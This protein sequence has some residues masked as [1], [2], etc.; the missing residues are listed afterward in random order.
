MPPMPSPALR[1]AGALLLAVVAA[2]APAPAQDDPV[3][4]ALH[5]ADALAERGRFRDAIAL[6]EREA[7]ALAGV[8]GWAEHGP[9]TIGF[10]RRFVPEE[11]RVEAALAAAAGGRTAALE[12]WVRD[13]EAGGYVHVGYAFVDVWRA[14]ALAALGAEAYDKVVQRV[15]AEALQALQLDDVFQAD[16]EAEVD[17]PRVDVP[18]VVARG[19]PERRAGAR[20]RARADLARLGEARAAVARSERARAARIAA[21]A[22][23]RVGDATLRAADA[24]GFTLARGEADETLGWDEAPAA[25]AVEARARAT[26]PDDAE[27]QQEL[28]GFALARGGFEVAARAHARARELD[29]RLPQDHDLVGGLR[30]RARPFRATQVDAA[31]GREAVVE[32]RFAAPVEA[33]D[34]AP[35]GVG[36]VAVVDSALR[37]RSA[38]MALARVRGAWVERVR[39][40]LAPAALDPPALVGLSGPAARLFVEVGRA[41]A[42]LLVVGADREVEVARA[43]H[44][45]VDRLRVEATLE[46][47]GGVERLRARLF[48]PG[49]GG[50]REALSHTLRWTGPVEVL[51]GGVGREARLTGLTIAGRLAPGWLARAEA[52]ALGEVARTAAGALSPT[53]D[54]VPDAA[55]LPV[56]Y[57][58]TSAEDALG[59]EGVPEA[60]RALVQEGRDLAR[61][62]R[63]DHALRA[64]E[65]AR[66]RAPD[67]AA[68]LYLAGRARLDLGDAPGAL[69]RADAAAARVEDFHEAHGLRAAALLRLVRV[70]EAEAALDQAARLAPASPVLWR[71]RAD[72]RARRGDRPGAGEAIAVAAALAPDD[73]DLAAIAARVAAIVE[74]PAVTHRR[75]HGSLTLLTDRPG[76]DDAALLADLAALPGQLALALPALARGRSERP[77]RVVVLEAPAFHRWLAARGV[78]AGPD[79]RLF[80]DGAG[81]DVIALR[82]PAYLRFRL[83]RGLTLVWLEEQGLPG[84]PPWLREALADAFAEPPGGAPSAARLEQLEVLATGWSRRPPLI[85][86]ATGLR[87]PPELALPA[88]ERALG[89]ALVARC[90]APGARVARFDEGDDALLGEVLDDYLRR[91]AA[92]GAGSAR[93]EHAWV[94]TFHEL[95]LPAL[96]QDL[97]AASQAMAPQVRWDP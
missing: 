90:L 47:Q 82:E 35:N 8:D 27:A 55:P 62:G 93:L 96:E 41:R 10:Y 6:L 36:D 17:G 65:A 7:P 33:A 68:A 16:R 94:Q 51:V 12:A 79:D 57:R 69:E 48:L 34:L 24:R 46:R 97:R 66:D 37:I 84:L 5:A 3:S 29:R 52:A 73:R 42:R 4:R 11:E 72:L 53:S 49:P 63:L 89:W 2:A 60:A 22:G 44:G 61:R 26:A 13:L 56:A 20:E 81:G 14:R 21:G 28:L 87:R 64:F 95:D 83:R 80:V 32:W 18:R 38:T 71:V 59:L 77:R 58:E 9:R 76:A 85:D 31:E 19:A 91:L 25:L 75:A 43:D 78:V 54:L 40:D 67:F 70:D 45:G 74:G 50:E 88:L 23:A 30:G 1:A 92:P 39:V 86:V 15:E